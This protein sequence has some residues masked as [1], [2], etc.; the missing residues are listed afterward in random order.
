MGSY[1]NIPY[2]HQSFVNAMENGSISSSSAMDESLRQRNASVPSIN[3]GGTKQFYCQM[4]PAQSPIT[5][6]MEQQKQMEQQ[7]LKEIKELAASGEED[8]GEQ[9]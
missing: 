2:Y 5:N 1:Y 6:V 8:L 9:I 4:H 7:L 3:T